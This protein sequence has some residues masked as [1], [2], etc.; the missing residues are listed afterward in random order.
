MLSARDDIEPSGEGECGN[1]GGVSLG[2][3][4]DML[5][6]KLLCGGI[7]VGRGGAGLKLVGRC[8]TF[9]SSAVS[10][11][12]GRSTNFCIIVDGPIWLMW[13]KFE[14]AE[15]IFDRRSVAAVLN[16]LDSRNENL[17]LGIERSTLP[18]SR[19]SPNLKKKILKSLRNLKISYFASCLKDKRHMAIHS[20]W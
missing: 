9:G 19:T 7:V 1:D 16:R 5:F 10:I 17:L 14:G 6:L 11:V 20:S 3:T 12:V 4:F 8:T 13:L 15:I 18:V 2:R